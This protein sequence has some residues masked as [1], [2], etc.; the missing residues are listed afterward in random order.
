MVEV[1]EEPPEEDAT[2]SSGNE[3]DADGWEKLMG[4][5]LLMK[6]SSLNFVLANPIDERIP[7]FQDFASGSRLTCETRTHAPLHRSLT[8]Q[9]R[10]EE[11]IRNPS[12]LKMQSLL[13]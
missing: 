11:T 6:V 7:V 9:N 4:D 10:W 13:I 3:T 1:Q 12:I 8:S 5:D 2:T